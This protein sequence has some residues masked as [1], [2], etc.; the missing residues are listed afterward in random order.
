MSMNAVAAWL[1]LLVRLSLEAGY[2]TE[3]FRF[4][5]TPSRKFPEENLKIMPEPLPST[6]FLIH[7]SSIILSFGAI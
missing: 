7:Y 2:L 3:I 1:T 4:F 6:S 5:L